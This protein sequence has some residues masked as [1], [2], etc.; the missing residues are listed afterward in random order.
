MIT[1]TSQPISC[2][3]S[4]KS[5]ILNDRAAPGARAP[6]ASQRTAL[7]VTT[8]HSVTAIVLRGLSPGVGI[9]SDNSKKHGL[10]ELKDLA[11]DDA[12]HDE[13]AVRTAGWDER[14][15]RKLPHAVIGADPALARDPARPTAGQLRSAV[16]A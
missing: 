4:T 13:L 14:R 11:S 1:E 16:P 15:L 5:E 10:P 8:H 2:G 3:I 12:L 7:T 9:E 6:R